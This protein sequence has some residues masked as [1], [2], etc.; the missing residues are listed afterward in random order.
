MYTAT[1]TF[2]PGAFDDEFHALNQAIAQIA[3]SIPG[4]LGEES[5]HHAGTG[6]V[7]NVYYWE[8]LEALQ[9]LVRHPAHLAA[10]QRQAQWLPGYQVVIAQVLDCHGDGRIRH[11]LA[12]R[13]AQP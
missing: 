2:Q 7:C 13:A 11:P 3:Q 1:F 10:K 6:L 12:Q 5:W 9:Q 8:T 4:Y